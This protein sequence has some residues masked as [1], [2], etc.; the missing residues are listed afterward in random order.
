[1]LFV[2][3]NEMDE[4]LDQVVV[5]LAE[6]VIGETQQIQAG[7]R[8]RHPLQLVDGVELDQRGVVF[9][10]LVG[11][12]GRCQKG[13]AELVQLLEKVAP[14]Y[15]VTQLSIAEIFRLVLEYADAV[16]A[17]VGLKQGFQLLLDRR[18]QRLAEQMGKRRR[19]PE[20]VRPT[21]SCK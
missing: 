12:A 8:C 1:L 20:T 10:A 6:A 5:D 11:Q 19:S 7:R 14:L 16:H 4:G 2:L 18:C 3:I 9:Y 15:L 21:I 17:F 13:L